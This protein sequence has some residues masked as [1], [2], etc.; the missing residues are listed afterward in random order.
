MTHCAA[1]HLSVS[2]FA[3][4]VCCGS[5]NAATRDALNGMA[6]RRTKTMTSEF[7]TGARPD[8]RRRWPWASIAIALVAI[9]SVL[10][11]ELWA[12]DE[13]PATKSEVVTELNSTLAGVVAASVLIAPAD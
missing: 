13:A 12:I 11:G 6:T 4:D 1:E 8:A 5:A 3:P 7:G 10:A 2:G 9:A